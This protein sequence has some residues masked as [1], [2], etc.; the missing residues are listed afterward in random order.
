MTQ[1]R[2]SVFETN[3]S[4]SHSISIRKIDKITTP[5][6]IEEEFKWR[7]GTDGVLMIWSHLLEFDR[8]P[9]EPLTSFYD[10]I[11]FAIASYNYDPDKIEN[12]K[13]IMLKHIPGLKDIQFNTRWEYDDKDNE[14]KVPD[15]GYIDHQSMGVLQGFLA[16]HNVS[17]EDFLLNKKYVVFIDGDEYY[18]KEKMFEAGLMRKE[19]FEEI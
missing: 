1:I 8:S 6:E 16:M 18:I 14:I 13:D 4:S 15:Y 7:L 5:E 17:L 3:S 9:F 10:K 19:D 2:H 11:R 12:I